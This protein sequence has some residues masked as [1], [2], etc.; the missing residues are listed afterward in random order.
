VILR[1]KKFTNI[2]Y[3]IDMMVKYRMPGSYS[4]I[5]MFFQPRGLGRFCYRKKPQGLKIYRKTF[6]V[7]LAFFWMIALSVFLHAVIGSGTYR[8]LTME[9]TNI[10]ISQPKTGGPYSLLGTTGRLGVV[11]LKGSVYAVEPGVLN[12]WRPPQDSVNT[13]YVYPNPCNLRKGCTGLT[14]TRLT[15]HATV[16]IY[17]ISGEHLRTIIKDTTTDSVGWDLK[18]KDGKYVASG[19]YLYFIDGG[20]SQKKGKIIIVR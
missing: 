4:G 10:G 8:I 11:S 1:N 6:L 9:P 19:L 15:L 18:T 14:F 2:I 16:K 20:N 12:S 13:A 7:L 17:T 3:I 5:S